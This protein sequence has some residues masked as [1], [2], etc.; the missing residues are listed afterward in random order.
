MSEKIKLVQ[1]DNLPYILLALTNSDGTPLDVSGATVQVSFREA[2]TTTVLA[3]LPCMNV[4]DGTDGQVQFNFPGTTL[5]VDPG[6][7][8]GEI[9]ID[10]G[11]LRQ[12]IYDILKFSVRAQFA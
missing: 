12:T 1:G 7:Y 5:D 9:E 8:E 6:M 4:T 11:G 10:F 2:G 3:V